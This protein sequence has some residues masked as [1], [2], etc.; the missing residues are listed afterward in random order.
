MDEAVPLSTVP[1][2]DMPRAIAAK[3]QAASKGVTRENTQADQPAQASEKPMQYRIWDPDEDDDEDEDAMVAAA[4]AE[5][6]RTVEQNGSTSPAK[7]EPPADDQVSEGVAA[8]LA[9]LRQG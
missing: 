2:R 4:I 3:N 6:M 1:L 5:S 7:P 9:R 8:A